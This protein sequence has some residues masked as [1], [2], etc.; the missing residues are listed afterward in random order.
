M[1]FSSRLV[2]VST[3]KESNSIKQKNIRPNLQDYVSLFLTLLAKVNRSKLENLSGYPDD[4]SEFY[5]QFFLSKDFAQ[6]RDDERRVIRRNTIR[7]FLE[8]QGKS[9]GSFLDVGCGF[10]ESLLGVPIEWHLYGLDYSRHNVEAAKAILKE[11]AVIKQGGIYEIPF[12]TSSM[13]VCC[14][15][16][17]LEHIE[18]DDRALKEIYRV[19]KPRGLLILSVP[20]TYYWPQYKSRIGHYRH[21]NRESLKSLLKQNGFSNLVYLPNYPHWN[22]KYSRQYVLTRI[23]CLTIGRV[24]NH[25]D[26]FQFTWPWIIR[27][28]NLVHSSPRKNSEKI[29]R[30]E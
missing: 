24:M 11:R 16:E 6:W 5:E 29:K 23:L 20:F 12:E 1:I 27:R 14:C 30:N 17:V 21:Y 15:L 13:D 26:V 25:R 4:A 9:P 7:E 18:D 22:L 19:L 3:L 10:G 28:S 8:S 2:S